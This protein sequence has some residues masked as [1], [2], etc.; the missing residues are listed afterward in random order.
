VLHFVEKRAQPARKS[1]A[2][3][4]AAS[5]DG[6]RVFTPEGRAIG[7][8]RLPERGA[9]LCFGVRHCNRRFMVASHSL[10]AL[11]VNTQATA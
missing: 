8:I 4:A 3:D 5:L 9:T 6:V 7:H 10:Y 1:W 2:Y 11:F